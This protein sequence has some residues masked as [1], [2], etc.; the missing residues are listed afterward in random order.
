MRTDDNDG[1][2]IVLTQHLQRVTVLY[3]Y[4][5]CYCNTALML[6]QVVL[7]TPMTAQARAMGNGRN[8]GLDTTQQ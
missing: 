7:N 3:A 1:N 8:N 5:I 4:F 6:K 2:R